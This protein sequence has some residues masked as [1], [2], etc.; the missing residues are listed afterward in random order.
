VPVP[1]LNQP[2]PSNPVAVDPNTAGQLNVPG[3]PPSSTLPTIRLYE[4]PLGRDTGPFFAG[5]RTDEV[6]RLPIPFHPIVYV[7][8]EVQA[9][10]QERSLQDP[11]GFSDPRAVTPGDQPLSSQTL[12]LGFD[13]NLFVT[14]AVHE[15]QHQAL[16]S[17]SVVA[18]RYARADL[19][20]DGYL[21]RIG[22][23]SEPL[24]ERPALFQEANPQQP[25]TPAPATAPAPVAA[26]DDIDS[27]DAAELATVDAADTSGEQAVNTPVKTGVSNARSGAPSFT[28][29]LRTGT[30]S[31]PLAPL[32]F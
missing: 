20:S 3:L 11:R 16:F 32:Q 22:L 26:S 9:V 12:E 8:R 28:E 27:A 25:A 4:S 21:S 24:L 5:D 23:F 15:S 14:R 18:G 7:N 2:N 19:S 6:R 31:L 13:P 1:E 30:A 17:N 29:Q 10:Q